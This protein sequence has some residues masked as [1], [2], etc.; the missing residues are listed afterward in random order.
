MR[1][2]RGKQKAK[3]RKQK[4]IHVELGLTGR[5]RRLSGVVAVELMGKQKAK[6]ETEW[7]S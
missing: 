2:E 4:W 5:N 6:V 3:S 1:P 7:G